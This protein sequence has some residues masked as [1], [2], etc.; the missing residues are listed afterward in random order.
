MYSP[1]HDEERSGTNAENARLHGWTT[2]WME[3]DCR[4]AGATTPGMGEVDRVGNSDRETQRAQRSA[5]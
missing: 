5:G 2:P 4:D 3:D 1:T